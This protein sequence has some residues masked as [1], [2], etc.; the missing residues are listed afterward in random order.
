MTLIDEDRA[1]ALYADAAKTPG[2]FPEGSAANTIAGVA[3][4]GVAAA[5]IGKVKQQDE[6][7]GAYAREL[8]SA[9]VA[10]D[11]ALADA[12]PGHRALFRLL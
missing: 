3:S 11:T 8:R 9:G 1:E 4:F 12:W 2:S 5:Y 10:Y 6:L 7:G